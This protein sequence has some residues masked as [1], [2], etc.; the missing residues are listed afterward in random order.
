MTIDVT[1]HVLGNLYEACDRCSDPTDHL[2]LHEDEYGDNQRL[3]C[4]ECCRDLGLS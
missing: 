2:Y 3:L 1:A 4:A